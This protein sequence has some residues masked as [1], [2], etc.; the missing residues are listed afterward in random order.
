MPFHA[1]SLTYE[2]MGTT[3]IVDIV[4]ANIRYYI[5]P[6]FLPAKSFASR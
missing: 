5:E 4:I 2:M 3:A 6:K 1:S